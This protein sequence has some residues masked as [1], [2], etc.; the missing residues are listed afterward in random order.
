VPF[1]LKVGLEDLYYIP[2]G[3]PAQAMF[4]H[5]R[6]LSMK[7]III[8]AMRDQFGM[9]PDDLA[10]FSRD[11]SGDT[12]KPLDGHE[13]MDP[14]HR[15]FYNQHRDLNTMLSGSALDGMMSRF[16]VTFT[17]RLRTTPLVTDEWT[18]LPDLF[19]FLRDEMF[20]AATASL[21][22]ERFFELCPDFCRDFWEYD[23][24][25]LTY[26]RRTPRWMAPKA[27]AVRDRVLASIKKW[28]MHA[29][30]H[31]PY[32]DP[33]LAGVEYEPI[34]GA[35]L[36]RARAEMF[37]KAGFTLDG[38]ASMDLGFVWASN[39]NVIPATAWVLLNT[40]LSPN[41]TQRITAELAS[42]L[43]PDSSFPPTFHLPTLFSKPLLT[44]TY[45]EALRYC[46]ATTS[47]RNPITSTFT[48][49]GF[50]FPRNTLLLS[51]AWFGAHDT[52]FWNTGRLLPPTTTNTTTPTPS[53][54]LTTYWAERFLSYPT[55]PS[56]GP[57][58]KPDPALYAPREE[59]EKTPQDDETAK[60]QG[61]LPA[62]QGYFYPYGGGS[63]IC[64]GRHLAKQEMLVGV[65]VV[66]KEVEMEVVDL[67]EGRRARPDLSV[68]PT[69][70]MGPDRGVRVRV[71]RRRGGF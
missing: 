26:L 49:A 33:A 23:S 2:H 14:A 1:R 27:Y 41:L 18:E 71:R 17:E 62:L 25:A 48:L 21:L 54:P 50:T 10:I 57:I 53:H 40:L 43:T 58:R 44:S 13:H 70:A 6:D 46:T 9:K 28:N 31:L 22:G 37:D 52:S 5:A 61:H 16:I 20:H 63:R 29:R 67:A 64:P 3:A 45:L 12:A 68:F 55:D 51:I 4:K 59:K 69:G 24:H 42:S 60:P 30:E 38:A 19:T 35:R 56:S 32:N 34:W 39:A 65:A 11:C 15:V 36:M 7:P 47:A 66:F 8:V